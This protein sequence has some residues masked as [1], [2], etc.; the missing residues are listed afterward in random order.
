MEILPG[1]A[2]CKRLA[3]DLRDAGN[4]FA[5]QCCMAIIQAVLALV[6]RSLGRITSAIFGWAVVALF[7]QTSDR[8]QTLLSALVGAAAAW[9]I[10][11][12]GVAFPK[13]AVFVLGFVPLP[14]WVPTWVVR[15]A[16]IVLAAAVPL[17]VGLTMA[18]RHRTVSA[19]EPMATNG[20]PAARESAVTRVLR[21][22]PITI[23]IAAAF[24]VVFVTVPVLR[25]ISFVRRR[26]DLH[27]PL[28]TDASH[29]P[30]I[31]AKTAG[32]LNEYGFTVHEAEPGWW[33][34]VPSR[35]L[36]S[37]GG[38]VFRE[39]VP[40]RLAYFAGERLEASLY[41][42]ALL[43]SGSEQDTAW[44][45]GVVVEAL[46]PEPALQ[47]FDPRAQ[48]LE[49][50]IKRIWSVYREN[51]TAHARS[52]ALSRRLIDIARDIRYLPVPYDEWQVVYREALQLSRALGG[53]EQLLAATSPERDGRFDGSNGGDSDMES[54]RNGSSARE[55]SNRALIGEI[56]EKVSM[57]ARKE[58][59][60]A[61]T[62]IRADLKTELATI[63]ALGVAAIAA[64]IGVNLILVAPILAL[65]L[66]IP[67][68]LAA[69][70]VGGAILVTAAIVGYIGWRHQVKTP[71][72]LT[73]QTLQE[74]MRWVQERLA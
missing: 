24:L 63:K 37:L 1:I 65:A 27:I 51:P 44:A 73:R 71:L 4:G 2:E 31:A 25:V 22:F 40:E 9:P 19:L 32:V 64:L 74:D 26:I 54:L 48:A 46:T 47:T 39:Y 55:L 13:I 3:G 66:V 69:L 59:E 15:V 67:G 41:P 62:E 49:R 35:I 42:N 53:E 38:P 28:I 20:R 33:M 12:L 17:A 30:A 8:E 60:L 68:W 57:L 16:W 43:L 61:K 6:S 72:P 45:H 18:M 5:D 50:Q 34:T 11:L 21:G 58:L 52:T 70:L 36:R 7:G 56:T 29:Y 23:A 10:L 14:T